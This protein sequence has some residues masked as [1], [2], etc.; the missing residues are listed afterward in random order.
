MGQATAGNPRNLSRKR[1]I[2]G[3]IIN[4][5]AE[6]RE[7]S[8]TDLSSE[9][10]IILGEKIV[11]MIETHRK[12]FRSKVEELARKNDWHLGKISERDLERHE[13]YLKALEQILGEYARDPK[14]FRV[15]HSSYLDLESDGDRYRLTLKRGGDPKKLPTEPE[16]AL[17]E[18][19][20]QMTLKRAL[21]SAEESLAAVGL[22]RSPA[23]AVAEFTRTAPREIE[24]TIRAVKAYYSNE[25]KKPIIDFLPGVTISYSSH[26]KMP[27]LEGN[28]HVALREF[29]TKTAEE[30]QLEDSDFFALRDHILEVNEREARKKR[31]LTFPS[32]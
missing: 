26:L 24:L 10:P 29:V 18:L 28:I 13:G 22:S 7:S 5:M 9:A 3:G 23:K 12:S 16:K 17:T 2:K 4:L 11:P 31:L 20:F 6:V 27:I 15:V 32:R 21:E 8:P 14:S 1:K 19:N 25:L 30:V